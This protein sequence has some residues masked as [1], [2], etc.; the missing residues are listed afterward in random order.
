MSSSM[1]FGAL[2]RQLRK[3][4]GMTQGDLA[5]ALG[6]SASFIG[7]LEQARRLPAVHT[8]LEQFVP[9]LGLQGEPHFAA[10][11]VELAASAR[12][13]RPPVAITLKR[14]TQSVVTDE[15]SARALHVPAA[16]TD[17]IGREQ[18][19][20]SLCHRLQGHRGRLLTLVG[21]PGIGKT[22]LALAVAAHL[23]SGYRDGACFV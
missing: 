1:A 9:A 8:V 7:G 2:L 14:E 20:R 18:E 17:L 15:F 21:P 12:G 4:A 22:T 10:R 11:L 5:A 3:R 16:P 19:M 13:E 23:Q 6:Y